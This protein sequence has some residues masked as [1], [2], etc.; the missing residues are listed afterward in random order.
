MNVINKRRSVRDYLDKEVEQEKIDLILKSAMQAPSACNQQG[1]RYL[2]IKDKEKLKCV[3]DKFQTMRFAH[4]A[5][6]IIIFLIEKEGLIVPNM[7]PVDAAACVENA[8]LEAT[9]LGVGSC[10]CGVWSRETREADVK[11]AFNIPSHLDPFA[12]VTFGYP[13]DPTA[14]KFIDRFDEAKIYYEEVKE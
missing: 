3:S 2:V 9:S 5:S 1:T 6:F 12:I 13:M 8:M 11:E 14:L 10:W 7:A 4:K